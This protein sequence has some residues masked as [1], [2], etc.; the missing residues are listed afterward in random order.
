V[1]IGF[2]EDPTNPALMQ[3]FHRIQRAILLNGGLIVP[4]PTSAAEAPSDGPLVICI[5]SRHHPIGNNVVKLHE[6]GALVVEPSW[7]AKK[8]GLEGEL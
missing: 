6:A 4:M 8:I 3:Q 5:P 7:I 1:L 2:D